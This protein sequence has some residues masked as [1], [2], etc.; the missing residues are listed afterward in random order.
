[1][2]Q[3][4]LNKDWRDNIFMP[5]K[6][7]IIKESLSNPLKVN[8]D[9][10]KIRETHLETEKE[11]GIMHFLYVEI[12]DSEK[13]KFINETKSNVKEGFYIHICKGNEMVV[14]FRNKVF[15]IK[16]QNDIE[17]ARDYG[18]FKGIKKEQLTFEN[19][20]RDPWG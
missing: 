18:L 10:R 8:M 3:D 2:G 12:K 11:R 14:I 4:N 1:M 7:V 9:V 15:R 17:K 5:W 16:N 6:G 13:E 20:M 19:L